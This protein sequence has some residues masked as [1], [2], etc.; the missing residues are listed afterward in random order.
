MEVMTTTS[1]K[2][3]GLEHGRRLQPFK[4]LW[5]NGHTSFQLIVGARRVGFLVILDMI[6]MHIGLSDAGHEGLY[7]WESGESPTY[8]NWACHE[9]GWC[10]PN[11]CVYFY[12]PGQCPTEYRGQNYCVMNWTAPF[13]NGWDDAVGDEVLVSIIEVECVP[14][15]ARVFH[16]T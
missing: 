6:G 15:P 12:P 2:T 13:L 1:H 4:R 7:T 9:A 5:V 11:D 14:H 3:H 10:E 16:L 8:F